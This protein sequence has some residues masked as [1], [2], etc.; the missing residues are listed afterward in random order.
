MV[1]RVYFYYWSGIFMA[2]NGHYT[3]IKYQT[4]N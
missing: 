1:I 4:I 2:M 3:P